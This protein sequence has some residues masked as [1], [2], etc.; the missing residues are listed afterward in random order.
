RIWPIFERTRYKLHPYVERHGEWGLALF[1][2]V[3]LPGTGAYSG[4]LGAFLLGVS[5]RRFMV[6]NFLGVV[7]AC[8]A[9]TVVCVL[10]ERGVVADDS[11][12]GRILIKRSVGLDE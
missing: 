12:A 1:I 10:I 5:R 8:I 9:V 4:A 11:L 6:A 3:P 7:V 2:G